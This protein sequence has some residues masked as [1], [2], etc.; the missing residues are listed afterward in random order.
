MRKVEE[1]NQ[2]PSVPATPDEMTQAPAASG[3]PV[4][5]KAIGNSRKRGIEFF[6]CAIEL[7]CEQSKPKSVP[8]GIRRGGGELAWC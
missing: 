1:I 3:A 8:L 4:G 5:A 7:I 6:A 2:V